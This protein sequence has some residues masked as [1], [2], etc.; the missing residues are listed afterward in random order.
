[1]SRD[2]VHPGG[3]P[4]SH[5]THRDEALVPLGTWV[6]A[7]RLCAPTDEKDTSYVALAPH[8]DAD[9]W[10]EDEELKTGL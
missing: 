10:T 3:S 1:M 7:F 2:S 9:L 5:S 8:L 6:E 4:G